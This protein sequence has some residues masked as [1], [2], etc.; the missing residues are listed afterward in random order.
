MLTDKN[1]HY[2]PIMHQS[3][4][5]PAPSGPEIAGLLTFHSPA[6]SPALPGQICGKIPA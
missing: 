2:V 3:F 4:V 1:H 5:A 6:K